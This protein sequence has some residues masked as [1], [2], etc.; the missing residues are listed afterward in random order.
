MRIFGYINGNVTKEQYQEFKKMKV[1]TL[2]IDMPMVGEGHTERSIDIFL[3]HFRMGDKL[4]VFNLT[5]LE[6]TLTELA[7]FLKRLKEK[8]IELVVL[9]KDELFES[10]TAYEFFDFIVDLHEENQKVL[11]EKASIAHKNK[12]NIG[13]PKV[14]EEVIERIRY[15]RIEKNYTLQD[16]AELCDV[17]LGTVYKYADSQEMK[18]KEF[19]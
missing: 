11:K 19:I 10:M 16:T 14:S 12:R 7:L 4:I 6:K 13:R 2:L 3:K 15:L 8:E 17:S 1:T 18:A 9:D 5:N